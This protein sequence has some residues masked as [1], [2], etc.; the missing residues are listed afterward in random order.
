M[1]NNRLWAVC[2]DD[3]KAV[4]LNKYPWGGGFQNHDEFFEKHSNCPSEHGC[5]ENILFVT[6]QDDDRVEKYDF[7]DSVNNNTKIYIKK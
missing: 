1:A 3:S 2:K 5:G 7:T 6:E 4:C